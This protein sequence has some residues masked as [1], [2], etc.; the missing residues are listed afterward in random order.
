M[1]KFK[2]AALEFHKDPRTRSD[3]VESIDSAMVKAFSN[4]GKKIYFGKTKKCEIC[5]YGEG[6]S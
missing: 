5:W 1:E 4:I 6:L 2:E 3:I